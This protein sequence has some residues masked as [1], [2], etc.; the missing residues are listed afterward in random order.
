MSVL[1]P[2]LREFSKRFPKSSNRWFAAAEQAAISGS[3][4]LFSVAI[5][6]LSGIEAFGRYSFVFVICQ[7]VNAAAGSLVYRQMVLKVSS[8][9][10]SQQNRVFA[11]TG[12]ISLGIIAATSLAIY[13][14]WLATADALSEVSHGLFIG[15]LLYTASLLLTEYFR[16]YLYIRGKQR[17]S[18]ALTCIGI[19]A[20]VLIGLA[21]LATGH[22]EN[23]H[24]EMFYYQAIGMC[25]L[26]ALN[27]CCFSV[28]KGTGNTPMKDAWPTF[29]DYYQRGKLALVG[30]LVTWMQNQSV[31]PLLM[32]MMGPTV[33]GTYNIARMVFMPVNV[34]NSGLSKSAL[35]EI[36]R[37]FKS[38]GDSGLSNSISQHTKLSMNLVYGYLVVVAVVV[39]AAMAMGKSLGSPSMPLYLLCTA[40]VMTL[41]NYRFWQSQWFVAKMHFETLLKFGLI[42]AIIT[43][44]A[45]VFSGE[46]L[47]SVVLIILASAIG[48]LYLIVSLHKEKFKQ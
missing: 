44:F 35:P 22:G 41:S 31:T 11:A 45:M 38:S 27:T 47:N 2:W 4:M 36:R 19:V 1:R 7:L 40:L 13:I 5:I 24:I 15:P 26:L 21:F 20:T 43:V 46:I 18:F 34:V 42:A 3:N 37:S 17:L 30:M 28:F 9:S 12:W 32:F 10:R 16:Q 6:S 29:V 48:E 39:F 8:D 33:V 25:I 23:L 14:I